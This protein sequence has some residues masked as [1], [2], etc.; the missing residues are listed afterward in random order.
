MAVYGAA[1]AA[2]IHLT[3]SMAAQWGPEVRVN[4]INPGYVSTPRVD[5]RRSPEQI[6]DSV[7]K[8]GMGRYGTPDDIAGA[9]MYLASDAAS[10]VSGTIID[11]YGG[12]TVPTLQFAGV[13]ENHRDR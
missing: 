12:D 8:I 11:V 3:K 10:W 6:R 2:I 1:K 5:A 7:K 13:K 4:C 9:A